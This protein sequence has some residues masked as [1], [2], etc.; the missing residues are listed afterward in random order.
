MRFDVL[1]LFPAAFAGPLDVSIIKRARE[2]RLIDIQ[3]HDIREHATGKHRAVDD[4]P[5]GGGQGMVMRVDVLD[6]AL[7]HVR[8]LDPAPAVV[9]YLTPQGD[10]LDDALVRELATHPRL[11]LVCGRYEGVDERFIEH[12][13]D[14]QVSIGDYILTG[15][16]LPAMV[17]IDAVARHVPDVLGDEASPQDE[18]FVDGLLEY[19]QYTR[20]AEYNGWP[21]PDVLLG[22]DHAAIERWRRGQRVARTIARRPDLLPALEPGDGVALKKIGI[23]G[24]RLRSLDYPADLPAV[25]ALWRA[26]EGRIKLGT[27]DTPA[28]LAKLIDRNP[29]LFLVVEVAHE[30]AAV[31]MA[32]FD[33]RRGYV[34]HLAV[35]SQHQRKGIATALMAELERRL[36]VRGCLRLNLFVQDGPGAAAASAFY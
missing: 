5:F 34:Y 16:E 18:S 15:G 22:G 2:D 28:E 12:R 26:G 30:I 8:A 36:R 35:A 21:V 32:G 13:V 27:S 25:L 24:A 11:I 10:R 19:A 9:V 4:Y 3:V 7:Q 1:T 23:D 17:L 14:R 29:G 31:V 33:G 20:P 6:A